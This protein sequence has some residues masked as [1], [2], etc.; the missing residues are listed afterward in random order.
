[1]ATK[2]RVSK[3]KAELIRKAITVAKL[4]QEATDA[5]D[6]AFKLCRKILPNSE[7]TMIVAHLRGLAGSMKQ[8]TQIMLDKMDIELA[9]GIYT[10]PGC[11]EEVST[12]EEH[13]C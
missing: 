2:K 4:A 11:Q 1:M 3:K 5:Q 6:K 8:G 9:G 7:S 10:C 13:Y 12:D